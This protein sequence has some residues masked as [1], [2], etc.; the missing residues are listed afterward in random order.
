M[1][2]DLRQVML[3]LYQTIV[4]SNACT[5]VIPV[6]NFAIPIGT[7]QCERRCRFA[8]AVLELWRLRTQTVFQFYGSGYKSFTIIQQ[9]QLGLCTWAKF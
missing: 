3:S 4:R 2:I 9:R 6:M 1:K 8:R 7:F 5:V